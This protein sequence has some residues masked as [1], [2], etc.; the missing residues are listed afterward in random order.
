MKEITIAGYS[1]PMPLILA[2]GAVVAVGLL[3]GRKKQAVTDTTSSAGRETNAAGTLLAQIMQNEQQLLDGYSKTVKESYSNLGSGLSNALAA[4]ATGV[5]ESF[6]YMANPKPN[7]AFFF[8]LGM[9]SSL[10]CY[11]PNNGDID[12]DCFNSKRNIEMNAPRRTTDGNA[13]A[14]WVKQTYGSLIANGK[15]DF[16]AAGRQIYRQGTPLQ[17]VGLPPS[18]GITR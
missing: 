4:L 8:D 9:R 12:I 11:N 7:D 16:V 6:M 15:I 3:A 2:G 1:F 13:A 18:G 14:E 17:N 10:S 5:Q